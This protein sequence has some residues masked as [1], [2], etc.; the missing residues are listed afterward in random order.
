MRGSTDFVVFLIAQLARSFLFAFCAVAFRASTHDFF[1]LGTS[2][3][4]PVGL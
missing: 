1:V 2:L 3:K 4:K